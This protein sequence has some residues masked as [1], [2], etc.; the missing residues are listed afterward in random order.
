VQRGALTDLSGWG[1]LARQ[2]D[3]GHTE[4][5]Q[6]SVF[7]RILLQSEVKSE[8]ALVKPKPAKKKKKV[9]FSGTRAKPLARDR[10]RL[11]QE[12]QAARVV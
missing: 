11:D 9:C 12:R 6:N 4:L 7:G 2:N 8:V 10:G 5:W 3:F 1:S